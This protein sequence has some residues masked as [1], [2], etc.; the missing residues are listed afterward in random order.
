MKIV[1]FIDGSYA[2]RKRKGIFGEYYY[3][4]LNSP[5]YFWWKQSSRHFTGCKTR[6]LDIIKE[7]YQKLTDKGNPINL[8]KRKIQNYE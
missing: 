3:L 6:R 1:Q 5:S 7:I 8:P 2:I 4:D